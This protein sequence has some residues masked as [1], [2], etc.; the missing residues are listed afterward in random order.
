MIGFYLEVSSDSQI[1]SV[2]KKILQTLRNPRTVRMQMV[3]T[4]LP[5]SLLT[6]EPGIKAYD[7]YYSASRHL[8]ENLYHLVVEMQTLSIS[9]TKLLLYTCHSNTG[10]LPQDRESQKLYVYQ[11]RP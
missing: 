8:Q 10:L 9:S 1:S 4:R 2:T 7:L 6:Q 3:C 11:S 5:V